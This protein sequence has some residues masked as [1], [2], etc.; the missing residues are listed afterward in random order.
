MLFAHQISTGTSFSN[1]ATL[2]STLNEFHLLQVLYSHLTATTVH[3]ILDYYM[4]NV[5]LLDLIIRFVRAENNLTL[6]TTI[7][8]VSSKD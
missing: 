1:D 2:I 6:F 4:I 8:S 7:F 5:L 3:C